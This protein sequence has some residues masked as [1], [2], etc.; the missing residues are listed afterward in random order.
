MTIDCFLLGEWLTEVGK[1]GVPHAFG[2]QLF[3]AIASMLKN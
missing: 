3:Y 2:L 1:C